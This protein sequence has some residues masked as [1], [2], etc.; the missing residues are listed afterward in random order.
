[1]M[2]IYVYTHNIQAQH[3]DSD[4]EVQVTP[5][6]NFIQSQAK[7]MRASNV[8]RELMVHLKA[9]SRHN[10]HKSSSRYLCRKYHGSHISREKKAKIFKHPNRSKRN[11]ENFKT[12]DA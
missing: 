12:P 2:T 5:K 1:M 4:P 9:Y 6:N 11:R 10:W 8:R 7:T 3:Y